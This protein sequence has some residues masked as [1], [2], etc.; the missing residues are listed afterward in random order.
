MSDRAT[1]IRRIEAALAHALDELEKAEDRWDAYGDLTT[2]QV[3]THLEGHVA[4]LKQALN[5][6]QEK[7]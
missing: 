1:F 5:L 7:T 4:G 2:K 3:V 6:I